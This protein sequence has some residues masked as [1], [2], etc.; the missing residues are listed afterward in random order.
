[1]DAMQ[2]SNRLPRRSMQIG[3][4]TGIRIKNLVSVM[5]GSNALSSTKQQSYLTTLIAHSDKE[6]RDALIYIRSHCN[7]SPTLTNNEKACL[8]L[9]SSSAIHRDFP[10]GELYH[11][12][13]YHRKY[14]KPIRRIIVAQAGIMKDVPEHVQE[15]IARWNRCPRRWY[16]HK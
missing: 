15:M 7:K 4:R 12:I 6:R 11:R 9:E 2:R 10:Y 16:L 5:M 8:V 3:Q 13:R 1:V 14:H